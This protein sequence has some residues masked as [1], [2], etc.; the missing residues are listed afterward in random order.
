MGRKFGDR[1][2]GRLIRELDSLHFVTGVIYPNRCDNEAFISETIDLTNLNDF[3]KKKNAGNPDYKYNLFQCILTALVRTITL[4]EKLNRFIANDNFYQRNEVSASFVVKK[5][6]ADNGG[7]ALAFLHTKGDNNLDSIHEYIRKQ[8]MECRSD[9]VDSSTNAMDIFN[10]MPRW[11]SKFVIHIMMFVER[12]GWIPRSIVAT[13]PYYSSV[14]LS[15]LGSIGMKSGYHHLTNWGTCS[16][17]CLIGQ[18]KDRPFYDENGNVTM[19]PSVDLG[20]TLDERLA[21]GYYYSKSVKLLKKLLE[22]PELLDEPLN[23]E[24]EI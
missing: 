8:V 15:N 16:M 4:R 1:K 10:K 14:V 23:K 2:D 9:K 6:F 20:I 11:F 7:E 3:L 5:Q 13:D 18:M 19:R 21:D 24:V 12:H 22:N 17:I